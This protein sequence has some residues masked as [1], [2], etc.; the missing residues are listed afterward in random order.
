MKPNLDKLEVIVGDITSFQGDAIVNAANRSLL[1]GGGVDGAIHRAAG[2][3]LLE[4]CEQLDGCETG[5]CKVTNAYNLPCKRVIHAVGPVYHNGSEGEEKKLESCYKEA[6]EIARREGLKSIAFPC[7]STG[8]YHYPKIE[9]ARIALET[10]LKF[11]GK[12]PHLDLKT[13]IV[14]FCKED[15]AVYG[16]IIAAM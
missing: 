10:I 6:L 16:K 7:I 11:Y 5:H 9:A 13:T 4:E 12:Y 1:G 2:P 3:G 15:M 8:V 14:C